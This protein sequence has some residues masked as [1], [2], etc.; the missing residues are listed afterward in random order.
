MRKVRTGP[1]GNLNEVV[2][3]LL[4]P[5]FERCSLLEL[6]AISLLAGVGEEMLFRGVA[7]P[8]M[9]GWWGTWAGVLVASLAFGVVHAVTVTYA[10]LATLVGV[11][12]GLM[13]IVTGNLLTPM[14][15]HALYDWIALI[16]LT[17]N[18]AARAAA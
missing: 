10:L 8:A 14:I 3:R 12:F 4:V 15:T 18:Y 5:L 17:R 1:L 13:A 11:Y 7:Q 2:D 16:Y 9:I 6:G